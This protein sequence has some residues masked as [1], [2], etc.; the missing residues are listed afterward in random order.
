LKQK[1]NEFRNFPQA[2]YRFDLQPW[3]TPI[4]PVLELS[5]SIIALLAM[6]S[7]PRLAVASD[8]CSNYA[9]DL[10]YTRSSD[11]TPVELTIADDD[12]GAELSLRIPKTFVANVGNLTSGRQCQ[13]AL[14]VFWPDLSPAGP[15]EFSKR[16]TR[17]RPVGNMVDWRSLTIDVWLSPH[18]RPPW[19]VPALYCHEKSQNI[20]AADRPYGLRGFDDGIR[21]P[22]RR[23]AD[24][25]YRDLRDLTA[26]PLNQMNKFFFVDGPVQQMTRIDCTKGAARCTMEDTILGFEAKTFFNQDD[27]AHWRDYQTVVREFIASHTAN[28][29]SART[30]PDP[31]VYAKPAAAFIACMREMLEIAGPQSQI[32]TL[33]VRE[34]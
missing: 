6:C 5:A 23:Q 1:Q 22:R 16:Y 3:E 8:V 29:A 4:R 15:T 10:Q 34:K 13:I 32:P 30:S 2:K 21:W 33:P 14:E 7:S 18:I 28:A 9:R 24:G 31:G 17:D 27:L 11:P 20:E 26:Y 12:H 19:L 25:S